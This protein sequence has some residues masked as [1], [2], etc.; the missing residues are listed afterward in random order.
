M[1]AITGNTYPVRTELRALGGQWDGAKKAWY[2]PDDRAEEARG[3]L[4]VGAARANTSRRSRRPREIGGYPIVKRERDAIAVYDT[5]AAEVVSDNASIWSL[6][7]SK[8]LRERGTG[9]EC[10]YL[11]FPTPGEQ[12]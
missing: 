5:V 6:A 4:T 1:T 10:V 11:G 3:L 2:V 7:K 12:R 9:N 8:A